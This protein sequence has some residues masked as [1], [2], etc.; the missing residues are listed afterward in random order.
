M[1]KHGKAKEISQ[2]VP[3]SGMHRTEGLASAWRLHPYRGGQDWAKDA[4]TRIKENKLEQKEYLILWLG[5]SIYYKGLYIVM[6]K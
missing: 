2:S 4:R 1:P 5:N 6:D 3:G